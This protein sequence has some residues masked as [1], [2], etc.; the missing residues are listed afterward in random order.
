MS[1]QKTIDSTETENEVTEKL[2]EQS[3]LEGLSS[4][5][6]TE[7]KPEIEAS[8]KVRK[9]TPGVS[10]KGNKTGKMGVEKFLMLYPQDYYIATLLRFY[11]P[12]SFFT[13]N[14][15]FQRIQEILS[16]PIY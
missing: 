1:K 14:E 8:T 5:V 2:V 12:N 10:T 13:K 11:Y 4:P 9:V 3:E 15:W 16:M 7:S 6:E